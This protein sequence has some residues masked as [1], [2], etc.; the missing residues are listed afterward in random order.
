MALDVLKRFSEKGI[1]AEQLASAKAYVK[2]LYPEI[3][4]IEMYGL[5]ATRVDGYF[6]RVD[7]VTLEQA[8]AVIG[9]YYHPDNLTVV[10]LGVAGK[11]RDSVKKYQPQ[12]TELSIKDAGWG[13]Y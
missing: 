1:T 4:E 2:G 7:A 10:I 13:G 9:K 8:N 3:G 12:M 11:I 5:A 6:S